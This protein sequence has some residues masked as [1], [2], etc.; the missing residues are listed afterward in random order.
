MGRLTCGFVVIDRLCG[1]DR[2]N[3]VRAR[4]SDPVTSSAAA[5]LSPLEAGHAPSRSTRGVPL[6]A[7]FELSRP[8]WADGPSL[9]L[10]PGGALGVQRPSQVCSRKRG[11]RVSAAPGPRARLVACPTRLVFVG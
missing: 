8:G 3:R 11:S 6:P 9:L 4:A 2:G 10:L 7:G 5:L 1:R